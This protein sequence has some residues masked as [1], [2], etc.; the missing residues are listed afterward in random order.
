MRNLGL[1]IVFLVSLTIFC[2]V[3]ASAQKY[4]IPLWVKAVAKWWALGEITDTEF[5][6]GMQWLID[7]NILVIPQQKLNLKEGNEKR[8]PQWLKTN[9]DLWSSG[10]ISD[11]N[12]ASGIQYLVDRKFISSKLL[13]ARANNE[14]VNEADIINLPN[15]FVQTDKPSYVIPDNIIIS[16]RVLRDV[17]IILPINNV[18]KTVTIL[19]LNQLNLPL[20]Y[21]T[22]NLNPDGTF[23]LIIPSTRFTEGTY[24]IIARYGDLRAQT[25]FEISEPP[26]PLGKGPYHVG[27]KMINNIPIDTTKHGTAWGNSDLNSAMIYYPA[28][29]DGQDADITTDGPFP[30]IVYA[31][32][33]RDSSDPVCPGFS[34]NLRQDYQQLSSIL[35]HLASWGFVVISPDMSWLGVGWP[36]LKAEIA[37]ETEGYMFVE[38]FRSTSSFFLKTIP[39]MVVEM[40]H[41][42]GGGG[43][44]LA[45]SVPF[46]R[47][48]VALAPTTVDSSSPVL[49]PMMIFYGTNDSG[50]EGADGSPITDYNQADP[51]KYL[52]TIEGANHFGYTDSVC[53]QPPADGE[54]S[55]SRKKQ[56][57]VVKGYTTAFLVVYVKGD[58]QMLDYL[59]GSRQIEGLDPV[60]VT[61]TSVR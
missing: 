54:E 21:T 30:L 36:S 52:V 12:F 58:D 29:W 47:P 28:E 16:G 50:Y 19:I 11:D 9:V 60:G 18:Q 6:Q 7:K 40:G 46:Y 20:S 10:K 3:D 1:M 25:S 49:R 39:F 32:G 37:G 44:I 35:S 33:Y 34:T 27:W 8:I 23:S 55:I 15:V 31:H 5:A 45:S 48:T 38:N 24:K 57:D 22:I 17:H 14:P 51:P 26:G 2:T 53:L 61:I 42:T 43:A 13:A 56:Q 41:S 4:E 59:S